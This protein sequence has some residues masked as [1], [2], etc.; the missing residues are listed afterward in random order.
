MKRIRKIKGVSQREM[1]ESSGIKLRTSWALIE[2]GLKPISAASI[3]RAFKSIDRSLYEV[4]NAG[5]DYLQLPPADP[6]YSAMQM[7]RT[8]DSISKIIN[9]E[10]LVSDED[11]LSSIGHELESCM[12]S[13]E[14]TP[15]EA[16]M[17]EELKKY[18]SL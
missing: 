17:I 10:S 6:A 16:I 13:I 11:R 8:L 5:L 12:Q 7:A 14:R 4:L 1:A 9:D 15:G 3:D 2:S 18:E